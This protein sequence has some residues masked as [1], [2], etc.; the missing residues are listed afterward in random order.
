MK[1]FCIRIC[2]SFEKEKNLYTH[3]A[4]VDVQPAL[5]LELGR[6]L[7]DEF[8]VGLVVQRHVEPELVARLIVRNQAQPIWHGL[9]VLRI[10]PVHIDV[11]C[12]DMSA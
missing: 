11:D 7:S 4:G 2:P 5:S 8:G 3:N 1:R 6:R 12:H 10:H 9:D